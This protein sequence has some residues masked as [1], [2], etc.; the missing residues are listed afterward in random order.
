MSVP[1]IAES[2]PNRMM[3]CPHPPTPSEKNS[4]EWEGVG[5][6]AKRGWRGIATVGGDEMGGGGGWAAPFFRIFAHYF[7]E[8]RR[9]K[10]AKKCTQSVPARSQMQLCIC[11]AQHAERETSAY[12]HTPE[13]AHPHPP[14]HRSVVSRKKE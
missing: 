13:T 11:A 14:P 4:V 12:S 2:N 9:K 1:Y 5:V 8:R 3:S 6:K 10:I 7:S